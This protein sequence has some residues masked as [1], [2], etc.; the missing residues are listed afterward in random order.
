MPAPTPATTVTPTDLRDE[1]QG[2]LYRAQTEL[3]NDNYPL[4]T[5]ALRHALQLVQVIA[6]QGATKLSGPRQSVYQALLGLGADSS[7]ARR[8]ACEVRE[9]TLTQMITEGVHICRS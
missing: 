8:A 4:A 5:V 6:K 9:G 2:A 7:T 1:F 3:Q